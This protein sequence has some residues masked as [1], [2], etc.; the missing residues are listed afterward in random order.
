MHNEHWI[1]LRDVRIGSMP[2]LSVCQDGYSLSE[3]PVLGFDN[4]EVLARIN[5]CNPL[6]SIDGSFKSEILKTVFNIG[7]KKTDEKPC[8]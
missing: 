4:S 7:I 1:S 5:E 6:T 8:G 3:T 2:L